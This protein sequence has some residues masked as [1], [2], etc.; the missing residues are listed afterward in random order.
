MLSPKALL[1][2]LTLMT[3]VFTASPASA[4]EPSLVH[5]I[6]VY[7]HDNRKELKDR[8]APWGAIGLLT[9]PDGASC[10]A[11][12]I[13]PNLILTNS[14]CVADSK[15]K[16]IMTG[17]YVFK[18]QYRRGR[19]ALVSK[20][21]QIFA[22]GFRISNDQ[23]KED[24][25]VLILQKRLGDK[26]GWFGMADYDTSDLLNITDHYKL[27]MAGYANDVAGSQVPIWQSCSFHDRYWSNDAV[28]THDCS[29]TMGSSGS[30]LFIFTKDDQGKSHAK[31]VALHSGNQFAADK[32]VSQNGKVVTFSDTTAN[33]AVH[34]SQF[35]ETVRKLRAQED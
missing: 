23:R 30:P 24:W 16:K 17:N 12:L 28:L 4:G 26:V 31:I 29:T 22:G 7:P 11:T 2:A 27:Y 5:K 13:G 19:A 32:A 35:I 1:S 34:V 3:Y 20:V 33:L 21:K 10:T 9:L 18:V 6:A 25:A 15:T 14:H 8:S